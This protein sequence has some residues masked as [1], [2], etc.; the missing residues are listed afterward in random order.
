M[1]TYVYIYIDAYICIY[2][3]GCE[4]KYKAPI[5]TLNPQDDPYPRSIPKRR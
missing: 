1:L 4:S 5:H 3:Y 2:I